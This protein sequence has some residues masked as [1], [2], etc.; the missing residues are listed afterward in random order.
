MRAYPASRDEDILQAADPHPADEQDGVSMNTDQRGE[1]RSA[2]R[3]LKREA[4]DN[5]NRHHDRR[6]KKEPLVA[7][8]RHE[9]LLG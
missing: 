3:Q 1:R 7:D 9:W 6:A 2:H 8:R 5:E 4:R